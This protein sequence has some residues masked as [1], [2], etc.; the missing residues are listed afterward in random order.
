MIDEDLDQENKK[1]HIQDYSRKKRR[2][3]GL[4]SVVLIVILIIVIYLYL[5]QVIKF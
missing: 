2:G 3:S 5:F 4:W 1:E